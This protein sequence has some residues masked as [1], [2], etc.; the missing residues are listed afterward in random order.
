M[1]SS[2]RGAVSQPICQGNLLQEQSVQANA[3]YDGSLSAQCVLLYPG[4]GWDSFVTQVR[5]PKLHTQPAAAIG[6][7]DKSGG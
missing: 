7:H 3:L 5:G 1:E 2:S 4:G 6:H